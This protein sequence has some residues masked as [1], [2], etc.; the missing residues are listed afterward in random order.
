[1]N[2]NYI[3]AKTAAVYEYNYEKSKINNFW[4]K[5]NLEKIVGQ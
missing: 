4:A 1:M 5:E 3:I 2:K